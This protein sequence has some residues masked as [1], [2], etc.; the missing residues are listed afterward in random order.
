MYKIVAELIEWDINWF[1][2]RTWTV[3]SMWF[4]TE[5]KLMNALTEWTKEKFWKLFE[6]QLNRI[7]ILEWIKDFRI[8][9]Y[10]KDEENMQD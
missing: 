6:D 10:I 3:M 5:E 1:E 9:V 2:I 4:K 7:W 8:D